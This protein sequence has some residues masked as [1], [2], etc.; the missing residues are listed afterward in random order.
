MKIHLLLITV[1]LAVLLLVGCS[2]DNS[3]S[4]HKLPYFVNGLQITPIAVKG[5]DVAASVI[6]ID[7]KG[8]K[9]AIKVDWGDGSPIV[10]T[11]LDSSGVAIIV[12]HT[13]QATG[14][15]N[16]KAYAKNESNLE[17]GVWTAV[18]QIQIL[19]VGVPHI[20]DIVATKT[21]MVVGNQINVNAMAEE[22]TGFMVQMRVNWDDGVISP[23]TV[24]NMPSSL[25]SFD[26][27]YNQTGTYQIKL[28][29]RSSADS[30][31][32]WYS[33]S[34]QV[35]VHNPPPVNDFVLIPA[36]SFM[37]GSS[38]PAAL[39]NEIPQH[40]VNVSAFYMSK[41]EV[42]QAEW[43]AVMQ[44][45]PANF[46][47]NGEIHAAVENVSWYDG[48]LYCNKRSILEGLT[49]CYSIADTSGTPVTNPNL[50]PADWNPSYPDTTTYQ[51][52]CDFNATGYRFPTEAEWEYAAKAGADMT[53]CGTNDINEL[54]NYAWYG[55]NPYQ[56]HI[57]GL[58]TPNVWGLYDMG[59]NVWEWCWNSYRLYPGTPGTIS[60]AN[61]SLKITR[62][63]AWNSRNSSMRVT[64]RNTVIPSLKTNVFGLRLVKK[65]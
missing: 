61:R 45:N 10:Y 58:K 34:H 51:I 13:Y 47:A 26:H 48:I 16:V 8:K 59:G 56:S 9:V 1:L 31:S 6:V 21:E 43:V 25:H 55:A 46:A 60:V 32:Q 3:T 18:R 54:S 50:W 7:P 12:H 5:Q 14:T 65:A 38:N 4:N 63:A 64:Y 39:A 23:W 57:V 33:V 15:F 62:G 42:S 41:F 49:P 27:V 22:L 24:M 40:N 19:N 20:V 52:V 30:L 29:A 36:G 28:Q 35:K 53:Y 37:M 11:P 2:K 17:S 44:N